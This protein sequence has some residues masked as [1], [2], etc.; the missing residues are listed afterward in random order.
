MQEHTGKVKRRL[1]PKPEPRVYWQPQAVDGATHR[2]RGLGVEMQEITVLVVEDNALIAISLEEG[3][4]DAGYRC[5]V[6]ATGTAALQMLEEDSTRFK[7]VLTDIHIGDGPNGWDVG[8]RARQ[9]VTDMPIVYMSGDSAADWSSKGV[10]NSLMIPKPYAVAQVVTAISQLITAAGMAN[11][12][13]QPSLE[14]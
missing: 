10:P 5:L 8:Q 1:Q 7:G 3:L 9:L 2:P 12:V 6:A 11:A 4:N 14:A 13:Q